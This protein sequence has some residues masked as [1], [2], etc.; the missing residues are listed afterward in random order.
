MRHKGKIKS[1]NDGKGYGFISPFD[2]GKDVFL[3]ISSLNNKQRRPK[4]GD[5]VT[6]EVTKDKDNRLQ[7]VNVFFA[8][9]KM[10]SLQLQK[11]RLPKF[12][13][14]VF[15]ILIFS[16]V[17]YIYLDQPNGNSTVPVHTPINT[18]GAIN[19]Q[20][21]FQCGEKKYCSDMTSCSE[22]LFYLKNCHG[23]KMDGDHD[24]IP[25]ES[26]WCQ[27]TSL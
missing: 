15:L 26:Q 2:G 22:A 27:Q 20:E 18:G 7:A 5:V 21:R 19:N 11:S 1:W 8:G 12:I 13:T 6:F 16:G 25:C 9:E 23:T 4:E 14:I 3:H 17:G 24:G 10:I